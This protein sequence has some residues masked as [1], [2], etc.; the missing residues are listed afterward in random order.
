MH[1]FAAQPG[2]FNDAEGIIDLDQKPARLVVLSAADSVLSLL[3]AR[4]DRLASHYPS[5]CLA[6]WLNL[7]KPA[8]F[9]LYADKVLERSSDNAPNGVEVV[10]LSLLGGASYWRYGLDQLK[11][12]ANEDAKRT[13]I[14]V[15]GEDYA[16][17]EL[18]ASGTVNIEVATRVWRYLREGGAQ[19][20][21]AF[22]DYLNHHFLEKEASKCN[23]S[24]PLP[25]PEPLPRSALYHPDEGLLP[26][27]DWQR[28]IDSTA[29]PT[30]VLTLYRSHVQS[31]NTGMFD[32]LILQI[33]ASGLNV[34][35]LTVASLKE[36]PCLKALNRLL[37]HS[38]AALVLNTTGFAIATHLNASD[39]T[40][41]TEQ[42]P[43]LARP[44]PVLQLILASTTHEQWVQD[45]QGLRARD[46][47][48][49]VSLPEVDGRITTRAIAFKTQAQQHSRS[50]FDSICFEL[51]SERATYV[52]QLAH[53]WIRLARLSNDQKH[54]ALVLANYPSSE[55]R[56][57]NG[58]GLDTPASVFNILHWLKEA[59]YQCEDIQGEL[60]A[61][62][63]ALMEQLRNVHAHA[64]Q[65]GRAFVESDDHSELATN[66]NDRDG[67]ASSKAPSMWLD[68][69]TYDA[70]FYTLP[71]DIQS[72]LTTR[73]GPPEE[74]PS[75][76][77]EK[78]AFALSL[79]T[80]GSVVVGVQPARGY[81]IDQQALYHDPDLIPPH[82]YLAFYLWLRKSF[83]MDAV[84]HVGK[85]GNQEWLP[86]KGL[87]LSN[88]C[89]PEIA[90]GPTPNIYPFIVND[91]GEGAQAKRR[92]QAVIID[93]LMP[94][95]ARAELYGELAELEE[96]ADEL[97]QAL[98]V[99]PVREKRLRVLI[100]QKLRESGLINELAVNN[101]ATEQQLIDEL[102]TY[103]CDIKEASIRNGLHTLGSL[104]KEEK[105]HETL[106]SL[107]RLPRGE[108]ATEQ[109]LL[110]ALAADLKLPS[111]YDPLAIPN[112]L[113]QECRPVLLQQVMTTPWVT[114]GDTR[115]RLEALAL[116]LIRSSFPDHGQTENKRTLNS[117][118]APLLPQSL[119]SET[120]EKSAASIGIHV[121]PSDLRYEYIRE[122]AS[123]SNTSPDKAGS[124]KSGI[125]P[126]P[127]FNSEDGAF[128]LNF[129]RTYQV[130]TFARDALFPA[131]NYSAKNEQSMLLNALAGLFVP[132]GASGAPTR[133][134]LDVLPTGRNFY[135]VDS[136]AIPSK[137]AWALGQ[138][139]ADALIERYLQ[140]QGDYPRHL[141]LSV[142][143]TATMRT[144][145][146]DI[147]QAMAL[148]GIEPVWAAGSQRLVDFKI[149][150]AFQ[151]GRPRVDVTLRVSGLF[152]DAFPNVIALL[153]AAVLKLAEYDEPGD[154]N[155]I[156]QTVMIDAE[157]FRTQGDTPENAWRRAC[158]RIFGAKP[159]AYGAGVQGVLDS[160]QWSSKAELGGAYVQWGGYVYGQQLD[161][162]AIER[163]DF[164]A[165]EQRLSALQVVLQNQDNREHDILDSSDYSAFHGGMTAATEALS[166]TIPSLYFGDHANPM[167][168]RIRSL[169]EEFNRVLRSRLLNPK[170]QSAMRE[171]GYKGASEMAAS[172]DNLFAFDATSGIV[173][174]YQY[175]QVYASFLEDPLN[176]DF[177]ADHNP[178]AQREITERLLEAIQ[179]DLWG[180]DHAQRQRLEE[181]LLALEAQRESSGE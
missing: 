172:V 3:A 153:D 131:L 77:I 83:C 38:D 128:Q 154:G 145:G 35:P 43:L 70:F 181:R 134:R 13:L 52:I 27:S 24:T 42:P 50:Q 22:F 34:L 61:S 66:E 104:P 173:D 71:T 126:V 40:S 39:A 55:A 30:V 108:G 147:A 163:A 67:N 45:T 143:G 136:R 25:A 150:P 11:A 48:M 9:D 94:P 140:E 17:P 168:P 177:F 110:H 47:A 51:D 31:A 132:P 37:I 53:A 144:G 2:G 76:N 69:V 133:G 96:L 156:R 62:P 105:L 137:T 5:L 138:Q 155:T 158:Y 93:H 80:L 88:H 118:F 111:E 54:I 65:G 56:I 103:L 165:F 4:A 123:L 160:G 10:V 19:N 1:L 44:V 139:S 90:L 162:D 36:A 91:P 152:R 98:G 73:W 125:D 159:G 12:W 72:A 60:P 29:R 26:L 124:N 16:D 18:L 178:G 161:G 149:I 57:G 114:T 59:G 120:R 176:S 79:M 101:Q 21:D 32:A 107:L 157:R 148:M 135:S 15:P 74:D 180:A 8:A 99:D 141:G 117:L 115:E 102:D 109:G 112:G 82:G 170:W 142:W 174:D 20:A 179:R 85:H 84:I 28:F 169:K 130:L 49:Q 122:D 64:L 175:T 171:H 81:D 63:T 6:N 129:P 68:R 41:P 146:D 7:K 78:S 95:M 166:G 121:R 75:Y 116:Q 113:W 86:G 119:L 33:Q 167:H 58:V 106:L 46:I 92:A 97:Y 164:V 89:W 23:G 14:V 151:L 87:A 127:T 100:A